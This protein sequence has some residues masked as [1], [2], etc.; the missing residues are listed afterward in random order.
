MEVDNLYGKGGKHGKDSGMFKGYGKDNGKFGKDPGKN[1][2][3]GKDSGKLKGYGKDG[4][5]GKDAGKYGGG[6]DH[7]KD[8][9]K[10]GEGTKINGYCNKCGKRGHPA[11]EC[12]SSGKG[13]SAV[14]A[15]EIA[16]TAGKGGEANL[17]SSDGGWILVIDPEDLREI[18]MTTHIGE[19]VSLLADSGSSVTCCGPK[20]FPHVQ[21]EPSPVYQH[22]RSANGNPLKHYGFKTVHFKTDYDESIKIKFE[23]LDVT[24]PILSVSRLREHG[25]RVSFDD[26]CYIQHKALPGCP[27]RR[28]GLVPRM[29]L[30]FLQLWVAAGYGTSPAQNET[31]SSTMYYDIG[32]KTIPEYNELVYGLDDAIDLDIPDANET[33]PRAIRAPAERTETT[34]S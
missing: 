15:N 7:T 5:F 27:A 8:G 21:I 29:G 26:D 18:F 3:F 2:K 16:D 9:G 14:E 13:V 23:V 32:D 11:K 12:R 19:K 31:R 17:I 10:K 34:T 4:K 28:L 22:Y 25:H 30:F 33:L 6:K 24:R 1:G 20:D